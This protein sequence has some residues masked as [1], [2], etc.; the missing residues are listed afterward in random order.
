MDTNTIPLEKKLDHKSVQPSLKESAQLLFDT[1]TSY[2]TFSYCL[3]ITTQTYFE[4][5]QSNLFWARIP[6]L[7]KGELNII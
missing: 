6:S 1:S 7:F 2:Y 3:K 4:E 5:L